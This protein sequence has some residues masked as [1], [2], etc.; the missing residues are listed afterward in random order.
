M[1]DTI[2]TILGLLESGKPELQVAAAQVLGEL[3][4]K[5]ALVVRSLGAAISRA[6]VG[7]YAVDAL[8]RIGSAAA[9][10][11]IAVA[12]AHPDQIGEQAMLLLSEAGA[13]GHEV[14]AA[15]FGTGSGLVRRRV[16]QVLGKAPSKQELPLFVVAL[17]APESCEATADLLLGKGASAGSAAALWSETQKV[18]LGKLLEKALANP[19]GLAELVQSRVLDVMRHLDPVGSRAVLVRMSE[20][21]NPQ[22]IRAVA[23]RS[24]VGTKLTAAKVQQLFE[25]LE[26]QAQKELHDAVREVLAG[27]PELPPSLVAPLKRMLAARH[28]EQKLFA[29]RMLRTVGGAEMAQLAIKYLAHDDL[30]F[31]EAA[32]SSLAANKQAV[33]LV[34]KTMLTSHDPTLQANAAA[35]LRNAAAHIAPKLLKQLVEKASKLLGSNA[36]LGDLV[37]DT[38]LSIGGA[39]L[40]PTIIDK[41]VRL[42]RAKSLAEA[43]HL[44]AKVANLPGMAAEAKFQLAVTNLQRSKAQTAADHNPGD[45]TMGLFTMLVRE[46]FP[47]LPR[48]TKEPSI[49]NDQLLRIGMHLS[50][51]GGPERR[52]GGELLEYVAT[53]TKGRA[54]EDARY[55]LRSA[56]A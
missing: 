21:G 9:L 8:G 30:R 1:N 33:D 26:D 43:L 34:A 11:E 20:P 49:D 56:L 53:R 24:L 13:A 50:R 4:S 12:L 5:E 39:K 47:L 42:R 35:V 15:A 18:A 37:L 55:A 40:A 36:R 2:K 6:L 25:L 44:L 51:S 16:L 45:A 23:L 29:L 31:R 17:L 38:V 28:A 52:F 27:L 7:R 48:L 3:G 46:G 19:E 10:S 32:A 14:L 22:A 41:A 54:S